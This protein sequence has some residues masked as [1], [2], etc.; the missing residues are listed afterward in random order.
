[1]HHDKIVIEADIKVLIL[2]VFGKMGKMKGNEISWGD[3]R[4]RDR[5]MEI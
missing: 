5:G 1:M 3:E 4:L 2:I